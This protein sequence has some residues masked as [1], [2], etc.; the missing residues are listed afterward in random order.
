MKES[1]TGLYLH[2]SPRPA[3]EHRAERQALSSRKRFQHTKA[4]LSSSNLLLLRILQTNPRNQPARMRIRKEGKG[5][6]QRV[7][8]QGWLHHREVRLKLYLYLLR[9]SIQVQREAEDVRGPVSALQLRWNR[10]MVGDPRGKQRKWSY[11]CRMRSV[12][13]FVYGSR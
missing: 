6:L 10:L 4:I 9:L 12:I 7:C 5:H 3:Q 2:H 11:L 1:R 8:T 13:L